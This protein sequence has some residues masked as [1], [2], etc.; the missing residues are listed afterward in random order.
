MTLK[1]VLV[2]TSGLKLRPLKPELSC[3][4][5]FTAFYEGTC[6]EAELLIPFLFCAVPSR[7]VGPFFLYIFLISSLR[8]SLWPS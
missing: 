5:L 4:F 3:H 8:G 6:Y 7:L 1:E 2:I